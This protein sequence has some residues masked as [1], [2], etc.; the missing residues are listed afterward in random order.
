VWVVRQG[1]LYFTLPITTGTKPGA[2]DYPPAPHGLPGFAVPVEQV[3]PALVPF[4]ELADGRVLVAADGADEID[5]ASDGRSLRVVWRRW[6]VVG[7]KVGQLVDPHITSEVVWRLSGATLTREEVLKSSEAVTLR[8]WWVALPTTATEHEAQFTKG[9]RR[10]RFE[11]QEGA[12]EVTATAAWPLKV[13][14]RATGDSTLGRGARGA[15]PLHLVYEARDLRLN[16]QRPARWRITLKAE[17][18]GP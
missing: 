12:L 8:H 11:A 2:A 9:Q 14:V 4:I 17:G 1:S 13:S 5:P 10:D 15:L 18:K 7:A 3:Y 6:A 16:P